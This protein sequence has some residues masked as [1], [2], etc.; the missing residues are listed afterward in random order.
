MQ[1]IVF[2]NERGSILLGAPDS[3]SSYILQNITNPGGLEANIQ[4]QRSPGQHGS[5]KKGAFFDNKYISLIFTIRG[6][7]QADISQKRDFVFGLFNPELDN[8]LTYTL[9]HGATST[10]RELYCTCKN[11]PTVITENSSF[12]SLTQ[13]MSVKLVA[14]NPFWHDTEATGITMS[15]QEGR[16]E[17]PLDLG[18]DDF[19]FETEGTNRVTIN[20]TGHVSCPVVITFNGPAENP[21]ILNETTGETIGI[22]KTLAQGESLVIVTEFGKKSVKFN[23]GYVIVDAFDLLDLDNDDFWSLKVGEN[24]ISYD[25]DAGLTTANVLIQYRQ[26][27]IGK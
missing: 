13:K 14:N 8:T 5:T 3:Q 21:R 18:D 15:L 22:L 23:N 7:S 25:A 20:N 26:R 9:K 24:V 1:E 16:F 27:Y 12:A 2:S 4:E 11:A 19:E 17:F 6:D 10:S